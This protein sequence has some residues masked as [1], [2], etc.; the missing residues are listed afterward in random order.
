MKT[1]KQ[2]VYQKSHEREYEQ[3]MSYMIDTIS[4]RFKNQAIK[5]LNQ[6]TIEKFSDAQIGN[7]ANIFLGLANKV[8][9][10]MLKQFDDKRLEEFTRKVLN[11]TNTVSSKQLYSRLENEIGISSKSLLDNE[12]M[13]FQ[14][15]ALMLETAQW[16]KKLRDETIEMYTANTLR[17]MTQGDSLEDIMSQFSGMEEKRKNHAKFTARNQIA[18]FNAISS[19]LRTQKLGITKAIWRTSKDERVRP[20]HAQRDGKEFDLSEGLYSSCDKKTLIP[21]TDFACRCIAE[22]ILPDEENI[23]D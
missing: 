21:G 19:K 4:K 20:C 18:N 5:Q 14:T 3:A 8:K 11:K 13:T 1:I 9:K 2:P 15:N 6:G 22:Y 10:K 23:D 16:A 12:G 17:A 7:Y